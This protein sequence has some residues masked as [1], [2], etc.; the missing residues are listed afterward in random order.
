MSISWGDLFT[1]GTLID[2]S[3]HLWRAKLQ[4]TAKDL[5]I[6]ETDDVQKAIRFGSHRLAPSEA[7]EAINSQ[8]R[9]YQTD[10]QEH[11]LAFPVLQGVRYVPDSEVKTLQTKLD[12][13]VRQFNIEVEKFLDQYDDMMR[14]MIPVI[15][16]A[17]TEAAKTPEAAQAALSRVIQNYP[18][19]EKVAEKFELEWNFFTISMPVSSEASKMAKDANSQVQKVMSSMLEELRAELSEKVGSLLSLAQKVKDGNSRD[20]DGFGSRSK[21][22]AINVLNKVDRLNILG[23]PVLSEQTKKLRSI[24][25]SESIDATEVVR[26]LDTIKSNLEVDIQSARDMA[27]KKLTGLGNRKIMM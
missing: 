21:E 9:G 6:D 4:L 2:F 7:F 16:Q 3:V 17:L 24:L 22:S 25:E 13:R 26:D 20:K 19:R 8:V 18:S 11:S 14:E 10:I 5:G 1:Q 12:L 23:D 27:E 15:E